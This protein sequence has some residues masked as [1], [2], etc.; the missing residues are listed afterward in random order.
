MIKSNLSRIEYVCTTDLKSLFSDWPSLDI[1][2]VL[3]NI[4]ALSSVPLVDVA[5]INRMPGR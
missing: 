2:S 4:S 1:L 5:N 3:A